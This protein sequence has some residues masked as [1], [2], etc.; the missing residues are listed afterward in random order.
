MKTARAICV[1]RVKTGYWKAACDHYL[2]LLRNMRRLEIVELKDAPA[3]LAPEARRA[4]ESA[5]IAESL[6]GDDLNIALTENGREMT[7]RQFADFL[8][9][10]D[11]SARKRPAF[12]IGGPF[13]L[14]K[15]LLA[16]CHFRLSLSPMT[17]PHE[18]ARVLLFEQLFRAESILRNSP[19][20]H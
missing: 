15:K 9:D 7:S 18:L 10:C 17:F 3:A 1:G 4:L 20:H 16:E 2:S 12:I 5:R 19:Y 14:D 8:R 13:G 6:R 11:E